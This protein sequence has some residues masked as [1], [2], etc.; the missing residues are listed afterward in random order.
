MERT[1]TFEYEGL[2][3]E[4]QPV[5]VHD[6]VVTDVYTLP[7]SPTV[8]ELTTINVTVKNKKSYPE[9]ATVSAYVDGCEVGSTQIVLSGFQTMTLS[10]TWTPSAGKIYYVMGEV[11]RMGGEPNM[12][13]NRKG[14]C[15]I[16]KDAPEEDIPNRPLGRP[17]AN[18]GP[19]PLPRPR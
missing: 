17:E 5:V 18:P 4:C 15:V 14:I 9:N 11:V 6:L 2:G 8:G 12:S 1:I 16:V 7:E 19:H 13:D 3:G 10:F